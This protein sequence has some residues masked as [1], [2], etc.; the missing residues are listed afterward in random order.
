[1]NFGVFDQ[2]FSPKMQRWA[3]SVAIQQLVF[4]RKM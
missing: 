3:V 1:M 4:K 2:D